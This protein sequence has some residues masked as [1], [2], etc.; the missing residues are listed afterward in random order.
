MY[1][2]EVYCG[3]DFLRNRSAHGHIR[4]SGSI[5][6]VQIVSV[7]G[8]GSSGSSAVVDLLSEVDG[9]L[10][11]PPEFR[12]I[13]DPGGVLELCNSLTTYWGWLQCDAYVK[14]FIEYTNTIGRKGTFSKW[15][16]G[17]ARHFEG[18]FFEERDRFVERLTDVK[19]TGN[20]HYD[21]YHSF[22]AL[23]VFVEKAK[24]KFLRLAGQDAPAFRRNTRK[25]PL[26]FISPGM[27][28]FELA[29][30]FIRRLLSPLA[31]AHGCRTVVLDQGVLPYN[32]ALTWKLLP[33]LR[34]VSVDRDPGDVY[35]D[36]RNYN[37]YPITDNPQDF[38]NFFGSVRDFAAGETDPRTLRIQ[39]EDLITAYEDSKEEIFRFLEIDSGQHVRRY[40]RLNPA[41]SLS[42]VGL[43]AATTGDEREYIDEVR[44]TLS[45]WTW[46]ERKSDR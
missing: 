14:R 42:N 9:I 15:G 1:E 8:F 27:P 38:I 6:R 17:Y 4:K 18:N 3:S 30:D 35:L 45:A 12:L 10:V 25:K 26:R 24:H 34:V 28:V 2:L 21:Y 40:E 7:S 46:Q 20:W 31:S 19:T 29:G 41:K 43:W 11:M 5:A 36:A 16:E 32:G 13:Q 44:R 37:A 39:F 33:E 22:S 23:E